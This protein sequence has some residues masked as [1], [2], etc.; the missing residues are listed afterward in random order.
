MTIQ[1]IEKEMTQG[2]LKALKSALTDSQ[3]LPL[4]PDYSDAAVAELHE[5]LLELRSL[6]TNMLKGNLAPPVKYKGYM[7][8]VMKSLQAHLQSISLQAQ[9]ASQNGPGPAKAADSRG[10]FAEPFNA[11]TQQFMDAKKQLEEANQILKLSL[12]TDTLTGLYNFSF[13]MK[14]LENEIERSRRYNEPLSI[15]L[16]DIDNFMKIN[17]SY[18]YRVGDAVLE[19]T[20]TLMR[21]ILRPSDNA[22]RYGGGEFMLILPNTDHDGACALAERVRSHIAATPCTESNLNVTISAGIAKWENHKLV[23]LIQEAHGALRAAKH[24]RK[25]K[26]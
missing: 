22:G 21:Q 19:Q 20:A 12:D 7:T 4:P 2:E 3:P 13:L 9:A 8:G 15:V 24:K 17:D 26:S 16:L 14:I 18:G 5:M 1:N 11:M 6:A 25:N 10:D 23:D